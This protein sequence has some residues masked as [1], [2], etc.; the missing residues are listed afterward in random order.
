MKK[1]WLNI[2]AFTILI[3]TIVL[4]QTASSTGLKSAFSVA[5]QTASGNYETGKTF[6]SMLGDIILLILSLVGIIAIAYIIFAGWLWMS[7]AGNEQKVEKAK[8]I[9]FQSII[10][11]IIIIGAYTISYFVIRAFNSQFKIQ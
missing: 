8:G 5:Q 3:P 9:L 10:G 11:L 6:E 2:I 4:A 1:I 7:A